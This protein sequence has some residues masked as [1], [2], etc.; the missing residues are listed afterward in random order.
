MPAGGPDG[1]GFAAP[2]DEASSEMF[3]TGA[4]PWQGNS[5]SGALDVQAALGGLDNYA[6]M[7]NMWGPNNNNSGYENMGQYGYG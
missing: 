1:Q 6:L 4:A 7:D 3:A 2:Y 5:E